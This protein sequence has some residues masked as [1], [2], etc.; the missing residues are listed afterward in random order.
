MIRETNKS[1]LNKNICVFGNFFSW[2]INY[3]SP[4]EELS[5]NLEMNGWTVVRASKRINKVRKL[6]DMLIT[7]IFCKKK[8]HLALIEVYSGHAFLWAELVSL[9][10]RFLNKPLLL[11]LHGGNLPTFSEKWQK[12]TMRLLQS[13][14]CVI[15]PSLFLIENMKNFRR[16]ILLI[17]NPINIGAYQYHRRVKVNPEIVWLR[18]FRYIYQPY[19][20]A[21]VLSNLLNKQID[22]S[23]TM[24]GPDSRDGSLQRTLELAK[25]LKIENRLKIISGVPKECVAEYLN[26]YEIFLNTSII[27]NTPISVIEAMACGLCIVSTNVGG[28]PYL[29]EHEKDALL[30]AP[31]DPIQM[32]ES[33]IRIIREPGL[34][35][36]L[37][38][39]AR[40][41]AE[42]FDWGIVLPQW[43][44]LLSSHLNAG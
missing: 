2:K 25:E 4:C 13:A 14:S 34:A 40:Q 44:S 5:E 7:A 17:P 22:A 18:K 30:V 8:Y 23:V 41:K 26:R 24:I 43:E 12:R 42:K 36:R 37:S 31:D 3:K 9:T 35:E 32:A 28:I 27:D 15:A 38:K 16:D 6:V 11:V 19:H 39:N 20:A 1:N 29:L 10:I 21:F 33:I